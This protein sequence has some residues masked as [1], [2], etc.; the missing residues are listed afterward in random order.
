MAKI[1]NKMFVYYRRIVIISRK[2]FLAE[3]KVNFA[4]RFW[5]ADI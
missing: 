1:W 5:D 4:D 2:R 3:Y